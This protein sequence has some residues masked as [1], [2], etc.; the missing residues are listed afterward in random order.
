MKRI[1]F[2]VFALTALASLFACGGG[3]EEV[4]D[5]KFTINGITYHCTNEAAGDLCERGNC[6]KCDKI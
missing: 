1:L 4:Y 3:S 6:S 2:S 5:G